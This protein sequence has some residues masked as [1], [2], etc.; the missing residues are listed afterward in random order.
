MDRPM[1][2]ADAREDALCGALLEYLREHPR[3]ME[4]IEGIAEWWIPRQQVRVELASLHRALERL[5]RIGRI[6]CVGAGENRLYR[7]RRPD[8]GA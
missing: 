7:L 4:T 1:S 8:G 3:A 5:E 6:E 2:G